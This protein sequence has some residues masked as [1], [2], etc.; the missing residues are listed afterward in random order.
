MA[1]STVTNLISEHEVWENSV[2]N[3]GINMRKTIKEDEV[4]YIR[5]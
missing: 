5:F 1:S 2:K 3:G 4:M